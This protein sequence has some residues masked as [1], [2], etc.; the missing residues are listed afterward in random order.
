MLVLHETLASIRVVKAFG[1][2]THEDDLF[3]RKSR[4]R[5][6]E[7]VHLAS[8]QASFHVLVGFAIAV[9][10]AAALVIGVGQVQARAITVGE[11]LLVMAYIAQL[12][13]PLRNISS[14]IPELQASI[15]SVRRAFS[16]LDEIPELSESP[17]TLPLKRVVGHFV[18]SDVSFQYTNGRRVLNNVSFEVQ[19]GARV[20]IA[21]PSGSGKT[22]LINMLTRFYDPVQGCIS[23]DGVDLRNYRLADLRQQF[24]IV[25]QEPMLFSTTVAANVAYAWPDANRT[26][27]MEAAKMAGAHEFIMRLPKGYDTPIGEGGLALSGGER[28][29]LAIA[30]AF[31]KD[32]PVLILDE[33]TSAVDMNAEQLIIDALE[34]LMRGRTTFMIAH[35]L[36]TLERSD[37]VLVLRDGRL[38]SIVGG[39]RQAREELLT[40]SEPPASPRCGPVL[41]Y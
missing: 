7:Q 38:N 41:V 19:P 20:G 14:K 3:R 23:L 40:N 28:Q 8:I 10:T 12:Y 37:Q 13:E 33:P 16:L 1:R 26:D 29:R 39:L 22:T 25:P 21:G 5:M 17:S 30:R 4:Q 35:R 36:S 18:F 9:G 2:E 11:L 27:V 15:S 34:K 6:T 32:A 24:S 31:L